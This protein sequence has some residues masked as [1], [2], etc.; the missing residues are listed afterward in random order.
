[1]GAASLAYGELRRSRTLTE[2]R[3]DISTLESPGN[4][5]ELAPEI[6]SHEPGLIIVAAATGGI[7]RRMELRVPH[8]PVPKWLIPALE[9]CAPLLLLPF[10]W[11]RG[12]APPVEL[13]AIQA[14]IDA[15]W[16]FMGDRSSIPQWTPTRTGGVQL[17]WHENGVDLEIEFPPGAAGACAVFE[18]N[19]KR[20]PD[21][22]GP[23]MAHLDELRTLFEERLL[24]Q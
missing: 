9:R 21:W 22:D 10:D 5:S 17:D 6:L 18:D 15:L 8:V 20:S 2:R 7:R 1:M 19:E 12:G 16:S 4:S 13:T 14:A 3:N 23:I 11:N 24:I